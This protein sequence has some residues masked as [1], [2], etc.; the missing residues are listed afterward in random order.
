MAASGAFRSLPSVPTKVG[1]LNQLPTLDLGD[2]DY[3]SC[4]EAVD[5]GSGRH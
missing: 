4:P 2:G 5:H 1:L 3:S